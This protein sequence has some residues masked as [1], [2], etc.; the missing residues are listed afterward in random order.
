LDDIGRLDLSAFFL[1]YEAQVWSK[2]KNMNQF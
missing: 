2:W 1:K